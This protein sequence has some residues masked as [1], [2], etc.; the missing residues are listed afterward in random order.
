MRGEYGRLWPAYRGL[1]QK[2]IETIND[3]KAVYDP[4]IGDWNCRS[5]SGTGKAAEGLWPAYRGLKPKRDK[6]QGRKLRGLWPAYRG[7]KHIHIFISPPY[8]IF[9][10]DPLIGDWNNKNTHTHARGCNSLWPAY[11]GL[12]HADVVQAF[13]GA[14]GLWPA[15]RGLK[16]STNELFFI[17]N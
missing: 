5:G 6:L 13:T 17:I 15:Y 9:V 1:K 3:D 12:K 7:L 2:L 4:L 10:Y 11:R 16:P 14:A 8:L